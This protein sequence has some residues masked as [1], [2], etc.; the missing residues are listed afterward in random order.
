MSLVALLWQAIAAHTLAHPSPR[1]LT[2]HGTMLHDRYFLP[3]PLWEDLRAVLDALRRDGL[4]FPV[5]GFRSI[6]RWRFPL[7]LSADFGPGTTLEVRR[8]CEGWPL[9]SET[10]S[11]GGTT[12]RFVDT[13]IERLEF[14]APADFAAGHRL[15]VNGREL[16]LTA[17]DAPGSDSGDGG[18]VGCGLRYRRTALYPSLHPGIKPH[19]PLELAVTGPDGVTVGSAYRLEED[20]RQFKPVA[21]GELQHAPGSSAAAAKSNESLLTYDLRLG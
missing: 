19:L 4:D 16:R 11:E 18:L 7:M 5:D 8:G 14:A 13:S 17:F 9:L 21:A 12:S 1:E 3:T 20:T 10:P 2:D 15:F 6:W